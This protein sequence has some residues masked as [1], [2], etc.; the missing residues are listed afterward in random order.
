MPTN[1]KG[2]NEA[3]NRF[4]LTALYAPKLKRNVRHRVVEMDKEANRIYEWFFEHPP[5]PRWE[6]LPDSKP[7]YFAQ[8]CVRKWTSYPR[9]FPEAHDSDHR[10]RDLAKGI[11]E[12]HGDTVH[13]FGR[14]TFQRMATM[15]ASILEAEEK[16]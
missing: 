8:Y 10:R 16:V 5:Y 14:R 9:R 4:Q 7:R 13:C 6:E 12:F 2:Q 11:A 1:R 15:V 3:N